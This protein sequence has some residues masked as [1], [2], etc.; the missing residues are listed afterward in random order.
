[1]TLIS[2]GQKRVNSEMMEKRQQLCGWVKR[3]SKDMHLPPNAGDRFLCTDHQA[4]GN[5]HAIL[6]NTKLKYAL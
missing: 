1:M 4:T 5:V 6:E 2:S 3:A